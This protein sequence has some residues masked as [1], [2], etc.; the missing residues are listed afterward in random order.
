MKIY[1][2]ILRLLLILSAIIYSNE[3]NAQT[4]D[5][6]ERYIN[7][8]KCSSDSC[9]LNELY[10][11]GRRYI[12]VNNDSL[13]KYGQ[14]VEKLAKAVSKPD[15]EFMG[16]LLTG[17][18]YARERR[19]EEADSVYS[20]MH[21]LKGSI[22]SSLILPLF[23]GMAGQHLRRSRYDSAEVTYRTALNYLDSTDIEYHQYYSG[24]LFN[25]STVYR[26]KEQPKKA[27]V[28][29]YQGESILKKAKTQPDQIKERMA[30]FLT[31]RSMI[32]LSLGLHDKALALKDSVL[33]YAVPNS[34]NYYR[35]LSDIASLRIQIKDTIGFKQC[36]DKLLS[37]RNKLSKSRNCRL[38]VSEARLFAINGNLEG[39]KR[40]MLKFDSCSK[41]LKYEPEDRISMRALT[42]YELKDYNTA[43]KYY[44]AY[45]DSSIHSKTYSKRNEQGILERIIT[46][47]IKTG[48]LNS[49]SKHIERYT[50]VV[51]SLV[52]DRVNGE[53]ILKE[54]AYETDKIKSDKLALE[55]KSKNQ[56]LLIASQKDN[57]YLLVSSLSLFALLSYFLWRSRK[58]LKEKSKSISTLNSELNHRAANQLS[59]AYELILDQRRQIG[60][61]QAKASLLKS[62]SQL[63]ALRE[64]NR[65]LANKS[66]DLVRADQVLQKV[67]ENLQSASPY[68]F[69]LDLQLDAITIHGNA[70]SRSALILS[71]L[72]SN[73][74]KYAFPNQED[75]KASLSL[76]Q[77]D[78]GISITYVDNGPGKDGRTRGTGVGSELIE[79]MLEDMDAEFE[80]IAGDE[81]TGYGLRWWWA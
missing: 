44:S 13:F 36:V 7:L 29:L 60:D 48:N 35:T 8:S 66:D 30:A 58:S 15:S 49:I 71:E 77:S 79:A 42:S 51:D 22:K 54:V 52:S 65:A 24:I 18:S 63:M 81:G 62:E 25:L 59:L 1:Y 23:A 3:I 57:I 28:S 31:E 19:Y 37:D 12:G 27:L 76:K 50:E 75:A 9:R 80:E 32:Y 26:K 55:A 41:I 40:A 46:C 14:L 43:L 69:K 39:M 78:S 34:T 45:Q 70:A 38:F 47:G 11:I 6:E 72:I 16:L 5:I 56:G 20:S 53:I 33:K 10:N 73:S 21:R 67:A 17:I 68:P 74:I 61:E 4:A 64:V 2:I